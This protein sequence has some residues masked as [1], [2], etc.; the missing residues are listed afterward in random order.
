[1]RAM[2]YIWWCPNTRP[3]RR[4]SMRS[5]STFPTRALAWPD[6]FSLPIPRVAVELRSPRPD[7]V[8]MSAPQ[9]NSSCIALVVGAGPVGLTMAAHLHH[10]GLACRIID[11]SPTPSDKSKAL[12]LWGRSL[13]MLDNLGIVANFLS[14][15]RFL[16]AACLQDGHR[17]L[18]RIPFA[19]TGT[20]Y[21]KPLMLAQS[22]TERL[23]TE[24]L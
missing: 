8:T 18:A 10:H 16:N 24:H 17:V 15:G 14:A 5:C 11:R 21:T 4:G 19:S 20:E 7:G 23:L 22:E 9:A 1:M 3:R 12:V 6:V 2:R 13:E